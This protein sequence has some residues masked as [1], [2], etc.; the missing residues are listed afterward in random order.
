MKLLVTIFIGLLALVPQK[1]HAACLTSKASDT[2]AL[3]PLSSH[4]VQAVI[5]RA[6]EGFNYSSQASAN[7]NPLV[8]QLWSFYAKS[9]IKS[10][11][12][13]QT[14]SVFE[15]RRLE[16]ITAC[17]HIDLLVLEAYMEKARCELLSAYE[18]E[19]GDRVATLKQVF[20]FLKDKYQIVAKYGTD[21][22]Y[23]DTTWGQFEWF[24][25]VDLGDTVTCRMPQINV[26]DQYCLNCCEKTTYEEC[27]TIDGAAYRDDYG[28]QSCISEGGTLADGATLDENALCPFTS[29]YLPPT[30]EGY[31][32]DA[33]AL[34]NY[35]SLDP[36]AA[37]YEAL[38]NLLDARNNFLTLAAPIKDQREQIDAFLGREPLDLSRFG[39]GIN[40]EHKSVN[41]C[42]LPFDSSNGGGEFT[43]NPLFN[44][45]ATST[46]L[47]GSFWFSKNEPKL[48]RLF[49]EKMAEREDYREFPD[50]LKQS[51]DFLNTDGTI[52]AIDQF[53]GLL[54]EALKGFFRPER[55]NFQV[56]Q[57]R[58]KAAAFNHIYDA[59]AQLKDVFSGIRTNIRD[60]SQGVTNQD[61]GMRKFA[62][63]FTWYLQRSCI[64]RPCN[65]TLKNVLQILVADECF[66][67][68]DGTYKDGDSYEKCKNALN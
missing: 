55:K 58:Q 47:R 63:G 24:D 66:P 5:D 13:M 67:Y 48:A 20:S 29:D 57:A 64:E 32:C 53:T 26:P 1:T 14:D 44:S 39:T 41:G 12:D 18:N 52:D 30:S 43:S 40:P 3:T 36:I 8:K 4:Y 61:A 62:I 31:G 19:E 34:A 56:Q 23:Q 45:G 51:S 46:E 15:S 11:V 42:M 16:E 68:A 33:T 25:P 35:N 17:Q 38:E 60:I 7:F 49:I 37:E 21:P 50:L 10:T 9:A 54:G 59:N 22:F 65:E 27:Q 2:L 28:V 6:E